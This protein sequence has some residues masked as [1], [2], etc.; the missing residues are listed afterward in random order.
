[1]NKP[2][3]T[4]IDRVEK[5]INDLKNNTEKQEKVIGFI[6]YGSYSEASDHKPTV[7]SDVDLEIIVRDEAYDKYL[8]NFRNWFETNFE[9]ILIE[10]SLNHL[11]KIFV[12]NDFLDL[13]IHITPLS[14]MDKIDKREL[15]YFPN[16]YT[17]L[18]DKSNSIE[19]KIRTSIKPKKKESFQRKFDKLNNRFWYFVQGISPLIER[20]EYWFGAASYWA[21]L[22]VN[23]CQLLRIYFRKEVE[24]NQLKHIE[25]V[26]EPNIL[27]KIQSLRNLQTPQEL[28]NKM[29]LLIEVYSEY[30]NKLTLEFNLK[31][32]PKIEKSVKQQIKKYLS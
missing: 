30:V 31:Y 18:F 15:N 11:E 13:Q 28:K 32:D 29:K 6:V 3:Q 24:Y 26:L 1:M 2:L 21:W 4:R 14:E 19:N 20:K 8:V 25:E 16:G 27:E 22:Y 9:P 5:L 23:L 7:Y 17:I 12:T 10:T